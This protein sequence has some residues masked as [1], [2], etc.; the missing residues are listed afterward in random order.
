MIK[1]VALKTSRGNP[2]EVELDC[3]SHIDIYRYI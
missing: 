2:T 3:D 1:G